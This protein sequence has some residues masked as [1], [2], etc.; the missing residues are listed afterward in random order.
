MEQ[1]G[2]PQFAIPWANPTTAIYNAR[3]V[4]IYNAMSSLVRFEINFMYILL[5]IA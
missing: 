5:K 4:K 2:V 1:N 3:A